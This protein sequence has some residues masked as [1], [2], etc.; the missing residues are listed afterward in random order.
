MSEAIMWVP[1]CNAEEIEEEDVLRFEHGGA[2]Y[3]V[4]RTRAGYFASDGRCTHEGAALTEGFVIDDV[5]ECPLHQGR[6]HIPSGRALGAPVCVN[7][8]VYPV[9]VEGGAVFIGLP[10]RRERTASS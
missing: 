1:A 9:R 3:A 5:I 10:A 8:R 4:Y 6:F 2:A 7:L